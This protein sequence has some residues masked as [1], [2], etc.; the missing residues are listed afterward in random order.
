MLGKMIT[1]GDTGNTGGKGR[2]RQEDCMESTVDRWIGWFGLRDF[3]SQP[4][5]QRRWTAVPRLIASH[6]PRV[7]RGETTSSEVR[8]PVPATRGTPG[9]EKAVMSVTRGLLLACFGL[10]VSFT[11]P[12]MAAECQGEPAVPAEDA[13]IHAP[14][15]GLLRAYVH[16]G[17]VDY[18]CFQVHERQLDDY[19][20]DL[21]DVDLG[22][23]SR[24]EQLALWINAYNA[25]TI[26]L[27]LTRYPKIASIKD[28]PGRWGLKEWT[29]GEKKYSL[30]E[31]EN[32]ILRKQ[33]HEPRI[34]FAIVCASKSCPDLAPEAYLDTRLDEQLDR[35]AHRF[36]ADTGKGSKLA[37]GRSPLGR[38]V[39]KLYLSSIFKWFRADF[40]RG[41]TLVDFVMPYLTGDERFFVEEA[42]GDPPIAFLDYDWSL[43]GK[44]PEPAGTTDEHK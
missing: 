29:V 42:N 11:V 33:F 38:S 30:D 3:S 2:S 24:G 19:L 36:V 6:V 41:G 13:G 4:L 7:P 34:H 8:R 25:F 21:A 44:Q 31:I 12:A 37:K 9:G 15:D 10:L 35:A 39:D 16:D 17:L 27:V 1:A 22:E 18:G 32:E 26:K 23:L 5:R 40:E 28:I 14:F 43:N 20:R